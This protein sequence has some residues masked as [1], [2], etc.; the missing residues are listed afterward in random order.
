MRTEPDKIILG[1]TQVESL[2][3]FDFICNNRFLLNTSMILFLNKVDLYA[4]KVKH[5]NIGSIKAFADYNTLGYPP[6]DY[7]AGIT[8]F[9]D[10]FIGMCSNPNKE[11]RHTIVQNKEPHNRQFAHNDGNF[12]QQIYWHVTCAT[13]T[14]QVQVIFNAC[15]EI[16]I[17]DNLERNG[18]VS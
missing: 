13:D 15:R 4:A 11:V 8:Y 18:F 17:R 12:A 14:A 6:N 1:V 5:V 7:D 9:K 10:K 16:I 2:E 3:L